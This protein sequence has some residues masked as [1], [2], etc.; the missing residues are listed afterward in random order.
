MGI[1][2]FLIT[3]VHTKRAGVLAWKSSVIVPLLIA[4]DGWDYKNL[5]AATWKEV[6]D[7][8]EQMRGL[9]VQDHNGVQRFRRM[10]GHD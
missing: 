9:L 10:D 4:L 3:L 2:F 7:Q 1:A 6:E 5:R 8:S